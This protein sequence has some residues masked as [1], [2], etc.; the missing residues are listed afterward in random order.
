MPKNSEIESS[1]THIH[2]LI[3][4]TNISTIQELGARNEFKFHKT[5]QVDICFLKI[6]EKTTM[7]SSNNSTITDI[8]LKHQFTYFI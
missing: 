2:I 1:F 5:E 4:T 6:P 8:I 7:S 3:T